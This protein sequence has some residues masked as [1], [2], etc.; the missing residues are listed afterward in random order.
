MSDYKEGISVVTITCNEEK[1]IADFILTHKRIADEIIVVD[2]GSTD[3]TI[4]IAKELGA[5]VIE[6]PWPG[7]AKQWN[8]GMR[9]A[10]Y[11][12]IMIGDADH[13]ISEALAEEINAVIRSKEDC[14]QEAYLVPRKNFMFGKWVKHGGFYPDMPYPRLFKNGSAYFDETQLVH[15]KV[16]IQSKR[17]GKLKNPIE[18]YTFLDFESYINKLNR[19]TTL[20]ANINPNQKYTLFHF[21][22]TAIKQKS[23]IDKA[24]IRRSF[25]LR[26]IGIFIYRYII[27]LGFLDGSLGLHM[28]VL[29]AFYEY[30]TNLKRWQSKK[31][32][33][34][35]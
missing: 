35:K 17:I 3:Q 32:G 28:A 13:R 23:A 8:V 21:I 11:G 5:R 10:D 20:E 26:P 31:N 7:Y 4:Q 15:E 16:I 29:S 24:A 1:N 30:V 6:N 22:K 9:K 27:R 33:M 2:G 14:E 18:H 34:L 25:P 19:Y 12:W